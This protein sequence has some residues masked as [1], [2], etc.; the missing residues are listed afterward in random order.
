M[1]IQDLRSTG[2][3]IDLDKTEFQ[4]IALILSVPVTLI[5]IHVLVPESV[6]DMMAFP[7]SE[8]DLIGLYTSAYVHTDL[9]HLF[10]NILAYL[11]AVAYIY[12]LCYQTDSQ[13]WFR[14]TFIL[15][16]VVLPPISTASGSL[17]LNAVLPDASGH[18]KGFSGVASGFAGFLLIAVVD[19]VRQ[20]NSFILGLNLGLGLILLF[21]AEMHVI[22]SGQ[23]DPL[24]MSLSTIGIVAT[25]GYSM[26]TEFSI[27]N[28]RDRSKKE[29][30][31]LVPLIA[32]IV[33]LVLF[34]PG[35][36]PGQL[37]QNGSFV[38]IFSHAAGF[39]WGGV[40]ST[41]SMYFIQ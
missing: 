35:M 24:V 16:L 20:R 5:L 39:V 10:G 4:D 40:L 27:S 13:Q 3:E 15:F 23:F 18:T 38:N 9:K 36:F 28:V 41:A 30:V 14:A 32:G 11:G 22:Y 12:W 34:I 37:V 29:L 25:V 7:Y 19:Y 26:W 1:S 6:K 2:I 31:R 21:L 8:Y 17:M 33:L